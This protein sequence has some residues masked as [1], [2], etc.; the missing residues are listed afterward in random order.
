VV[1]K[2]RMPGLEPP[3]WTADPEGPSWPEWQD[4][5]P[6]P[7]L[8]PDHPSAP[9]PRVRM[10]A[11]YPL[12]PLPEVRASGA[13]DLPHWQR[14]RQARTWSPPRQL[15]DHGHHNGNRQLHAVSDGGSAIDHRTRQGQRGP[16]PWGA[17]GYQRQGGPAGPGPEP[18][19]LRFQHGRPP[20]QDSLWTAAQ[21]LMLADGRAAQITQEA[22]DSA[23]AIREAAE[24][25]AAAIA[26][27]A[28]NRADEMTRQAAAQAAAIREAAQRDDSRRETGS[29]GRAASSSGS[30][31]CGP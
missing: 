10:S 16:A 7:V 31:A 8:P 17:T 9:M 19:S 2:H 13:P 12:E 26:Q 30:Q 20:D 29:H 11:G 24:R 27:Q 22:Q 18:A 25:Q 14:G 3:G 1:A 6:P 21:V 28:S 5:G 23:A 15:A 4:L